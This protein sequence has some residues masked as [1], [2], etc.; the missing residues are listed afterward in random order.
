MYHLTFAELT[1]LRSLW[2][3]RIHNKTLEEDKEKYAKTLE[4]TDKKGLMNLFE[5]LLTATDPDPKTIYSFKETQSSE[6]QFTFK[7]KIKFFDFNWTFK[8][9]KVNCNPVEL[10]CK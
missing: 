9:K 6:M 7:K 10:V 8:L 4:V 3:A 2:V 1:D 5:S